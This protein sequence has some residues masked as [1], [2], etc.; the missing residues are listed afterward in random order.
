MPSDTDKTTPAQEEVGRLYWSHGA[1]CCACCEWW[2][3][4]NSS[5]GE[6]L[7]I[8]PVG[9]A[10]RW[11]MIGSRFSC[12]E[13]D[14]RHLG[15]AQHPTKAKAE[16]KGSTMTDIISRLREWTVA[17]MDTHAV[18]RRD[19]ARVADFPWARHATD[20]CDTAWKAAA[21]I[22]ALEARVA[23][24]EAKEAAR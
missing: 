22:E 5:I 3:H 2:W 10:E 9:E 15:G 16:A 7:R 6:C 21:R 18:L 14:A 4:F 19:G 8:P 23:V 12:V 11:A 24:L 20:L 13:D 1:P 17:D